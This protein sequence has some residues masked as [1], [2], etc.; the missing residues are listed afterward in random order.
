M[1]EDR[2]RRVA[3]EDRHAFDHGGLRRFLRAGDP[4][5]TG[6]RVDEPEPESP[7]RR[8]TKPTAKSKAKK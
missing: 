6:W 7:K 5:P 8:A 2:Q 1:A 3:D 4:L